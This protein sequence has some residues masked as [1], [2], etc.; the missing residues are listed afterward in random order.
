LTAV[1]A[2]LWLAAIIRM[3]AGSRRERMRF[4]LCVVL[5]TAYLGITVIQAETAANHAQAVATLEHDDWYML[6]LLLIA[7]GAW[8]RSTLRILARTIVAGAVL[9]GGYATL[10]WSI[11][12]AQVERSLALL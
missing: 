3:F 1:L 6:S 2:G 8:S 7:F 12:P 5:F 9:V 10:R 11:G 4:P